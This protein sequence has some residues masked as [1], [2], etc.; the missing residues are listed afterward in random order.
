MAMDAK[1]VATGRQDRA[2]DAA[3]GQTLMANA[4]DK[5][6]GISNQA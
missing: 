1:N 5:A 3:R 6:K 2:G 4:V